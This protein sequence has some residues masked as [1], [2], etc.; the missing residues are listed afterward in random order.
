MV[1]K[2]YSQ[3]E[4]IGYGESYAPVARYSSLRYI[5]SLV[6]EYDLNLTQMDAV[7]AFLNGPLD[8]EVYMEQPPYLNVKSDKVCRLK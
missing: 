8:E 2:G 4:G 5:L 3:R 6:G 1:A 7:S